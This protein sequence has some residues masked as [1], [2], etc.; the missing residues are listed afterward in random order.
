VQRAAGTHRYELR[1]LALL[2]RYLP[3]F[4]GVV[5][6]TAFALS[7]VRDNADIARIAWTTGAELLG[8]Y[9]GF[10]AVVLPFLFFATG[11]WR[12]GTRAP[13]TWA[14][15]DA[16]GGITVDL[17]S[18]KRITLAKERV[19][20]AYACPGPD[21]RTRVSLELEGGLTDGDR[22]VLDLEPFLAEPI[23][24]RFA[25]DAAKFDLARDG[26][27]FGALINVAA[28]AGGAV[29]ARTI[30]GR[31][32]AAATELGVE[33]AD[34]A[35]GASS[36]SLGLTVAAAG[37]FHAVASLLSS[38]PTVALGVDGVRIEGLFR[39]RFLPYHQ[40]RSVHATRAG[41]ALDVDGHAVSIFA[42]SVGP[43]RIATLVSTIASRAASAEHAPESH[44]GV[45]QP[46]EGMRAVRCAIERSL[47]PTN[48]R[49]APETDAALAEALLAPGLDRR[50]RLATAATL[51]ARGTR[52]PIRV[53]AHAVA[54]D[55]TRML[56]ERLAEEEADLA[57]IEAAMERAR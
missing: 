39:R 26:M 30:L 8:M 28:L 23:V 53:A 14:E 56:L 7:V 34:L 16:S 18:G 15:L 54:D 57:S 38:P 52:E 10:A 6:A 5:L 40:I 48:Y 1:A 2:V 13:I 3:V 19:R 41:I 36:W 51:A 4:V 44:R 46:G 17:A 11:L 25:S 9:G 50:A 35:S 33:P 12:R 45:E 31:L 55:T 24:K 42:P 49:V 29:V 22:M 20:S 21:G 27:A 43:E 37:F 32:V 47:E